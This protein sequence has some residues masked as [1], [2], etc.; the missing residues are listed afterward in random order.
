[1]KDKTEIN[2]PKIGDKIYVPSSYYCYR[3]E[4]DFAGGLATIAKIE[5]SDH[6]PEDHINYIMVGI[7]NRPQAMYNYRILMRD[8]VELEEEYKDSVAHPCPDMSPEFNQPDADWR[9]KK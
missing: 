4:D 8:Q 1:M 7:E 5:Y 9:S 6:L 3:G 2:E